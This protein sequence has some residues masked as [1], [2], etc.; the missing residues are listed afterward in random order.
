[1]EDE[2]TNIKGFLLV[3]LAWLIAIA[4]AYLVLMKIKFIKF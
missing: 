3:V 2:K 1:M 4:F